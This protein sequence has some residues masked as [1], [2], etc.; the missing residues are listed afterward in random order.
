MKSIM[1]KCSICE[2]EC[3][4]GFFRLWVNYPKESK[5]FHLECANEVK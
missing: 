5:C 3:D 2:K 1:E 4:N